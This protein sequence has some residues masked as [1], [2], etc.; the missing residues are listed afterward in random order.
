MMARVLL[1]EDDYTM[2][3]LLTTL[4][5]IEGYRII[6]LEDDS[7]NGIVQAICIHLPDI[8]LMDVNLRRASGL[9]VIRRVRQNEA[10]QGVHILMSSGMDYSFECLE[11]GADQFILK[12][13]MPDELIRLIQSAMAVHKE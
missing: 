8:V 5:K 1:V 9:E 10:C 7:E 6:P 12:P 11:A 13:F 2:L 3:S 4:L